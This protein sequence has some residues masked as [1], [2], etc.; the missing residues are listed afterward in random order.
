MLLLHH[1]SLWSFERFYKSGIF[2]PMVSSIAG[3]F[4]W[5][6]YWRHKLGTWGQSTIPFWINGAHATSVGGFKTLHLQPAQFGVKTGGDGFCEST[7]KP[8]SRRLT[9]SRYRCWF[10]SPRPASLGDSV[11]FPRREWWYRYTQRWNQQGRSISSG[12]S[13]SLFMNVAINPD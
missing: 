12:Q 6:A 1:G 7:T 4:R 2:H 5:T 13:Y 8:L 3:E 11:H 9:K 10:W